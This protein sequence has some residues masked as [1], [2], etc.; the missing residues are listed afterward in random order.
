MVSV[1][2]VVAGALVGL[3]WWLTHLRAVRQEAAAASKVQA[4][5]EL[6]TRLGQLETRT[7]QLELARLGRAGR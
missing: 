6:E 1:G 3:R 2:L 5:S 4:T 7:T